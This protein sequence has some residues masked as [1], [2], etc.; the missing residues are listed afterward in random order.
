M[1]RLNLEIEHNFLTGWV[2]VCRVTQKPYE[3]SRVLIS[4]SFKDYYLI[5][6]FTK[7]GNVLW[8]EICDI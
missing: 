6:K 5:S 2:D 4:S 1:K 3:G 7:Y 8:N